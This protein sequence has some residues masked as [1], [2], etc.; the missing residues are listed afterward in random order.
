M[1][2]AGVVAQIPRPPVQNAVEATRPVT[3]LDRDV[4]AIGD[5]ADPAWIGWAV[6]MVPGERELC[7]NWSDSQRVSRGAVLETEPGGPTPPTFVRPE[8]PLA[9]EEGTGLVI[10]LRVMDHRV[11]RIRMTGNNCP[12]DAGGRP[13]T[14]LT[15]VQPS[16]SLAYLQTLTTIT[17]AEMEA[18]RR[19][20]ESAIGAIAL[21][22]DPGAD[23]VLTGIAG[24]SEHTRLRDV[25]TQWLAR[26]RGASGFA[27]IT[28]ALGTVRDAGHRRSLAGALGQTREPGTAAALLALARS[29]EDPRA[30]AEALYGY[31]LIGPESYVT[32]VIAIMAADTRVEVRSRGIAGLLRRSSRQTVP[33]LIELARST[34]D[35]SL[36]K[37]LV[38]SLGTTD[39]A[40]ARA[41]IEELV[42]R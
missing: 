8:G 31:A 6:P 5:V 42:M 30:R 39:D 24:S 41:Y 18:R 19:L 33:A 11:E 15:G 25:A 32:D 26:A 38:R 40:R 16:A 4:A 37:E 9:L 3:S 12:L 17:A 14:W 10:L 23:A 1:H 36:R 13:L 20:A 2:L 28:A 34:S 29:D 7:S 21:H 35:L 27:Y 22:R